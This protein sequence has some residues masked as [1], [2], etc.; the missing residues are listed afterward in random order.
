MFLDDVIFA[1]ANKDI[2]SITVIGNRIIRKSPAPMRW[3]AYTAP[4]RNIFGFALMITIEGKDEPLEIIESANIRALYK[5]VRSLSRH[6]SRR[7]N[8]Q[9]F[10]L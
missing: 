3:R 2:F 8:V 1:C 6:W 5:M 4:D 7:P 10:Q 9:P